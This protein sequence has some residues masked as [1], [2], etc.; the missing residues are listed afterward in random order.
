MQEAK[1]I[2]LTCTVNLGDV[3][4][5]TSAATLIKRNWPK[6]R[7]TFLVK[8]GISEVLER[9]PDIDEVIVLDNKAKSRSLRKMW[10]FVN[11]IRRRR[12]DVS[13]ALDR[14]LRP[15]LLTYLAGVP[16]RIGADKVFDRQP[17]N[18][19]LWLYNEIVKTPDDFLHTHQA[20]I[21]QSIVR[22]AF[23]FSG[24]IRPYL[25][26]PQPETMQKAQALLKE[27]PQGKKLIAICIRGTYFRRNW[28]L[29]KFAELIERLS[30]KY[31][32][33][34]VLVGAPDDAADAGAVCR[35]TQ[36]K[37]TVLDLCGKTTL[38]ELSG[39]LRSVDLFITIDTGSMHI[40][41]ALDVPTVG[42]FRCATKWRW[43]PFSGRA[44]VVTGDTVCNLTD[45]PEACPVAPCKEL[46]GMDLYPCV[47][48]I[49]VDQ[50]EKAVEELLGDG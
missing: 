45:R 47:A 33:A 50:V 10:Q 18:R 13:I 24:Q 11:E 7:I 2:L 9:H 3:V 34:F 20:E 36:A 22:E 14:K 21:F 32:A 38:A 5:A 39:V 40:A 26:L 15:A 6:C 4:L 31:D 41:A 49:T 35:L 16:R 44:E 12:F 23:G 37:A 48:A 42:I 1:N 29:K 43:A 27:M 25:A 46:A 28:P 17:K 8:R 19:I 30:L